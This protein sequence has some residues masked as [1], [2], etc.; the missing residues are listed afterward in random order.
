M[1][2]VETDLVWFV[3]CLTSVV[4]NIVTVMVLEIFDAEVLLPRSGTAQS[5]PRSSNLKITGH[6]ASL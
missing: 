6:G 4:S 2:E 5:H 1:I 3:S